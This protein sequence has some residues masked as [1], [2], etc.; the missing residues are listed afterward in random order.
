MQMERFLGP[1]TSQLYALLR[2]VA[3]LLFACHGAQKLFGVL[4]GVGE[5]PGT[6]V[7]LYSLAGLAGGIE[8]VGGLCITLGLLTSYAAFIASGEMAAAYFTAHAPRG[9]WPLQNNGE[10]AILYC[11]LFLYMAARGAGIWSLEHR[12]GAVR[13]ATREQA[14]Y[15]TSAS[16]SWP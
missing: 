8:L 4:G 12:L 11:F 14:P 2:I 13:P 9:F 3:G 7:P 15:H 6:A 10:L 16:S 5:Q 1:W